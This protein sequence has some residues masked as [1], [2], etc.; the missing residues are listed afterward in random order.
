MFWTVWAVLGTYN[1]YYEYYYSMDHSRVYHAWSLKG[2]YCAKSQI[3]VIG[4]NQRAYQMTQHANILGNMRRN[5]HNL[6][7]LFDWLIDLGLTISQS[8]HSGQ[9]TYSCIS[10]FSN[11]STPRNNLPKQLAAFP[12]RLSPF[13]KDEW[14]MSQ[15]LLS[16]VGKKV[17]GAGIRTHNPWIDSP[18]RYRLSYRDS[19]WL[20]C[21]SELWE[22]K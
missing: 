16:N 22:L 15:W 1:S 20:S 17:E 14:R 19:T 5:R 8:Y 6:V 18:R 2:H 9:L 21:K 11:T 7:K 3:T 10:W 12:H 13:V 4:L